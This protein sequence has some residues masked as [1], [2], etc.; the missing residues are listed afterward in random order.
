MYLQCVCVRECEQW[1]NV[2]GVD[3][4]A[5]SQL[6]IIV[7]KICMCGILALLA[8]LFQNKGVF[9]L[10]LLWWSKVVGHLQSPCMCLC[11]ETEVKM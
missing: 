9:Q 2:A 1:Q 3:R 8:L 5:T 7:L 4:A 6:A 10:L 11:L